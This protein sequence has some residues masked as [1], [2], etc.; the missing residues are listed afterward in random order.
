MKH[1][2]LKIR[3]LY[4]RVLKAK[5]NS[6]LRKRRVVFDATETLFLGGGYENAI[7]QQSGRRIM[8]VA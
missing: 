4:A 8:V 6:M 3:W 1:H 2:I 7:L 5:V